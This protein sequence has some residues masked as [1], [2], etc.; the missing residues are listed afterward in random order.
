MNGTA[1]RLASL[2]LFVGAQLAGPVLPAFADG[3][4]DM[5]PFSSSS[6]PSSQQPQPQTKS[7]ST[8]ATRRT[9]KSAKQSFLDDPAF[10]QGYH[11]AY[12]S[13]YDRHDY[14]AAIDE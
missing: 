8:G 3:G 13:I 7:P 1:L 12:T 5:H 11:T 14:A 2:T 10:I 9:K 6:Q 4:G